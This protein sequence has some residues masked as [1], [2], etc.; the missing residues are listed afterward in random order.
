M[1]GGDGKFDGILVTAKGVK[2]FKEVMAGMCSISEVGKLA[3]AYT[4]TAIQTPSAP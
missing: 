1:Y 4:E 2:F 3:R